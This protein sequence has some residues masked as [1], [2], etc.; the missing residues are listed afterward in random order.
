MAL[1]P[2]WGG[3]SV[4]ARAAWVLSAKPPPAPTAG[5]GRGGPTQV[6]GIFDRSMES[7]RFKFGAARLAAERYAEE[8]SEKSEPSEMCGR[9][10]PAEAETKTKY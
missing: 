1:R 7:A 3:I 9:D 6:N 4:S 5:S 8:K 10:P 2:C